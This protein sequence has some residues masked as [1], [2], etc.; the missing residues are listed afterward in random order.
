MFSISNFPNTG[1]VDIGNRLIGSII[2]KVGFSHQLI[3]IDYK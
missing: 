1:T 2:I 3:Y